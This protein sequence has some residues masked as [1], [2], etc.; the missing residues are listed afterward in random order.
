[1]KIEK[2]MTKK[3][4]N[5]NKNDDLVH[6][7]DLMEK[8]DITKIPVMDNHSLVGI[9]T[10]NKITDK[11]G[12]IKSKGIPAAR[13][14]ASS[15]VDKDFSPVSPH[16]DVETILKT[17]GEPGLTMLPVMEKE[18]L[19]GVV[20]KADLL[21]LITSNTKI[22]EVMNKEIHA[23]SPEDRVVHARRILLDN[24]IGRI[25]VVNEGKVVGVIADRE[26]AFAFAKI[27]KSFSMG[28]QHHQIRELLVKDVMK[29][30]VI[31]VPGDVTVKDTADLMIKQGVG[32]IP[33]VD[34]NEKIRGMVTRTD[35]L[36]KL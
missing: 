7:L 29:K 9:V 3:I 28:Q 10:D 4:I 27:K 8:H 6:V 2:V 30:N 35:L 33:I 24:D 36:K 26:I 31:T 17:V 18:K 12:S 23:V 11:L 1:M 16:D 21:P 20:T 25:P 19:V 34:K 14:H 5:V 15:V 13:M 32:C 22:K